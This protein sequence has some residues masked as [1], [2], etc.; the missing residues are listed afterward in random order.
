MSKQPTKK[1]AERKGKPAG[2]YIG[3]AM[4]AARANRAKPKP[5]QPIRVPAFFDAYLRDTIRE[6]TGSDLIDVRK[7]VREELATRAGTVPSEP[8]EGEVE[9]AVNIFFAADADSNKS[10]RRVLEW[11]NNRLFHLRSKP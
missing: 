10:M 9:R 4:E 7:V 1:K 5:K 8:T 3:Q 6:V 11:W 2:G